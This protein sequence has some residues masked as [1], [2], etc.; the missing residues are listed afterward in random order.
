MNYLVLGLINAIIGWFIPDVVD[1]I[2]SRDSQEK[3]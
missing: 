3:R 1:W 2:I